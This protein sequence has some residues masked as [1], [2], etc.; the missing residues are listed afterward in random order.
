MSETDAS[1]PLQR[2]WNFFVHYPVYTNKDVRYT[3]D[4]FEKSAKFKTVE[5]FWA[6]FTYFVKPSSVFMKPG[7]YRL[8]LD[9]RYVEALGVFEKGVVPTWETV[10]GGH[11]EFT[12]ANNDILNTVW[13]NACL[14][15][16]GETSSTTNSLRVAGARIV[17]KCKNARTI[18]YRLEVWLT[19]SD[20]T[21]VKEVT[22]NVLQ[23]VFQNSPCYDASNVKWKAH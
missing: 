14:L 15:L 23:H 7:V 1:H 2:Q 20:E 3:N 10:P 16:I 5:K 18:L 13:E 21:V 19:T 17:D 6:Y 22:D 8:R 9:N 11:L 12:F 4:A